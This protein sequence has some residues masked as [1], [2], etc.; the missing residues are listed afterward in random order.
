MP[1]KKFGA[2][3]SSYDS[4]QSSNKSPLFEKNGKN[5]FLDDSMSSGSIDIASNASF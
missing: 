5:R 3:D 4:E 1:A 2:T